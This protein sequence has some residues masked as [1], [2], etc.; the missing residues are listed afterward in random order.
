MW[1]FIIFKATE[2]A[3]NKIIKVAKRK[4]RA[5][6]VGNLS[7]NFNSR[8][9]FK[10]ITRFNKRRWARIKKIYP[11]QKWKAS[12]IIWLIYTNKIFE[13]LKVNKL[14]IRIIRKKKRKIIKKKWNYYTFWI[15][16]LVKSK[17]NFLNWFL[18]NLL[19]NSLA[20]IIN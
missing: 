7:C 1:A 19:A 8:R 2:R 5:L 13:T 3:I 16:L 10:N 4:I 9:S 6:I 15:D 18:L 11:K 12:W 20:A 14:K 17:L